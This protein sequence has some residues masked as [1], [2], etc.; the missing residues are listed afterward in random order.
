MAQSKTKKNISES[1]LIQR[2]PQ[3]SMTLDSGPPSGPGERK[4]TLKTIPR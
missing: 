3:G 1:S 4:G 2:V